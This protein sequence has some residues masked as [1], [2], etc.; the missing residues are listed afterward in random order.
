MFDVVVS[1]NVYGVQPHV[2]MCNSNIIAKNFFSGTVHYYTSEGSVSISTCKCHFPI[3]GA[4]I[5]KNQAL[6]EYY[7]HISNY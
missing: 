5:S 3:P 7:A 4:L 1:C 2:C 6:C